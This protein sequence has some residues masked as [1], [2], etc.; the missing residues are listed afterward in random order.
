MVLITGKSGTGKTVLAN[1]TLAKAIE[2]A[3]NGYFISGKYDQ[4]YKA[5]SYGPIVEAFTEYVQKVL[6]RNDATFLPKVTHVIQQISSRRNRPN[7]QAPS[8]TAYLFTC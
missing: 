2:D 5:E 8:K 3:R 1:T 4:L 7:D 6:Q